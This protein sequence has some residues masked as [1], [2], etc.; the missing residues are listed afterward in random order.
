MS[1]CYVT[2]CKRLSEA[3]SRHKQ[4][5]HAP[6]TLSSWSVKLFTLPSPGGL[7]PGTGLAGPAP[8]PDPPAAA[9]AVATDGVYHRPTVASE[10]QL[11]S[12]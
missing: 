12:S 4:A 6:Y 3:S 10:E 7:P 5:L 9:A 1:W 2:H 8:A 11:R